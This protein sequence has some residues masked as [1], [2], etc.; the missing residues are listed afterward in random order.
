MTDAE[1][2]AIL[3][4][5][6]GTGIHKYALEL[7]REVTNKALKVRLDT[8]LIDKETYK[9]LKSNFKNYVP[10]KG[11]L[12]EDGYVH[13]SGKGFNTTSTGIMS[14]FGRE[15]KAQNPLIQAIIDYESAV[16][17]AE[18]NKVGNAFLKMVQNK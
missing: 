9:N 13:T 12:E 14:A 1:A 6:K 3:K 15:S 17:T 2:D 4:K 11:L 8:G 10:L 7:Y 16:Y 5:H 18:K